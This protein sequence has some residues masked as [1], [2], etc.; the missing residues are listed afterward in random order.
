[1]IVG[2]CACVALVPSSPSAIAKAVLLR[3]LNRGMVGRLLSAPADVL[4]PAPRRRGRPPILT[5][6]I[7]APLPCRSTQRHRPT[8]LAYTITT[9]GTTGPQRGAKGRPRRSRRRRF[10]CVLAT[11]V[12]RL[13]AHRESLPRL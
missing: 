1:G 6:D 8:I 11:G 13:R 7:V 5:V 3:N 2:P 12:I 10:R 9:S 4:P